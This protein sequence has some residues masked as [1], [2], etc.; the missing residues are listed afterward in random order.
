MNPHDAKVRDMGM[1]YQDGS[2]TILAID[3]AGEIVKLRSSP[4][5]ATFTVGEHIFGHSNLA[6][7]HT[8]VAD[9]GG[10]Q[11]CSLMDV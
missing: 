8:I 3:I 2:P 9:N 11:E 7:N 1:V 6:E 5:A 10:L 4:V